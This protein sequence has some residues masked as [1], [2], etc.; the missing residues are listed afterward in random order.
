MYVLRCIV[1]SLG[2]PSVEFRRGLTVENIVEYSAE[3]DQV[4]FAA[5]QCARSGNPAAV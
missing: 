4:Q 3:F 5:L 1:L 2:Y